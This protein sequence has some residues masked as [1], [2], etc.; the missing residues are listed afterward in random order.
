MDRLDVLE[1]DALRSFAVFADHRNF[2]SAAVALCISQPSL[3]VKIR[4]LAAALGTELYERDGR[5]LV[6]TA[7]GQRLAAFALDAHARSQEFLAALDG[8]PD[9]LSIAAGRGAIQ[10]VIPGAIRALSSHGRR[11]QVL[12]AG[13]EA[14][15]EALGAGQAD[16]AVAGFD[17]PPRRFRSRQIA[18]YPQVLMVDRGHEPRAA[19]AW[20]SPTSPGLTWSSRRRPAAPAGTRAGAAGR[21]RD[22]A[23]GRRGRRLGPARPPGRPWPWRHGGQRVRPAA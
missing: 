20:P 9:T 6:L 10:W 21:G 8:E 16:L 23:A 11:I 2:T 5:S 14:A 1:S 12:T 13:R 3:H 4:K 22:L 18:S 15:I 19:T 7:A 17:P